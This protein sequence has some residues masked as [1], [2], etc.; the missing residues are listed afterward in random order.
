MRFLGQHSISDLTT[1]LNTS[2]TIVVSDKINIPTRESVVQ[3]PGYGDI[4]VRY[5]D[6]FFVNNY[7][8]PIS[9]VS[10]INADIIK[11]VIVSEILNE[12]YLNY[13]NTAKELFFAEYPFTEIDIQSLNTDI[14]IQDATILDVNLTDLT[15]ELSLVDADLL[16]PKLEEYRL[17]NIPV[18]FNLLLDD[19]SLIDTILNSIISLDLLD[20]ST[21]S[22][23]GYI[24]STDLTN[25]LSANK[26]NI[27]H[28]EI[29]IANETQQ[30]RILPHVHE[31]EEILIPV[32]DATGFIR[33]EDSTIDIGSPITVVNLETVH[34]GETGYIQKSSEIVSNTDVF[35]LKN[36]SN[37]VTNVVNYD[38]TWVYLVDSSV[39]EFTFIDIE[40]YITNVERLYIENKSYLEETVDVTVV[41][42]TLYET[43]YLCKYGNFDNTSNTLNTSYEWIDKTSVDDHTIVGD[44][45]KILLSYYNI[46]IIQTGPDIIPYAVVTQTI[47]AYDYI[48]S[49]YLVRR[50]RVI[51]NIQETINLTMTN[52][53][54]KLNFTFDSTDTSVEIFEVYFDGNVSV[55]T[56]DTDGPTVILERGNFKLIPNSTLNPYHITMV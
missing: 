7:S 50:P 8:V 9:L 25:I 30:R 21:I 42:S 13:D 44:T 38:S 33:A 48:D 23:S 28:I 41:D 52:P 32:N 26:V 29:E 12:D 10:K 36:V 6:Y 27:G 56:V 34:L 55:T 43:M 39:E 11:S 54:T 16:H 19:T 53:L 1:T 22:M 5:D 40:V 49:K 3:G 31:L 2:E 46:E 14:T 17:D 15:C 47:V 18:R 35:L 20:T 37:D 45:I 51:N 4:F 24:L